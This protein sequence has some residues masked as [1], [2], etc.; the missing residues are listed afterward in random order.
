M[1]FTFI[2]AFLMNVPILLASY[3]VN[4]ALTGALLYRKPDLQR[5]AVLLIPY[6]L[7]VAI[8]ATWLFLQDLVGYFGAF[9]LETYLEVTGWAWQ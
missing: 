6:I 9:I 2:S 1:E 7:F 5:A 3:L 8:P 4:L